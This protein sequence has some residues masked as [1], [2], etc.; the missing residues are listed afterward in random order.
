MARKALLEEVWG[1]RED[2]DTRTVDNFIA[3]LRRYLEAEPSHPR[4]LLTVRGVG[5]R[6]LAEPDEQ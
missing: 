5:Y 4:H 2:T 1:V 6:F 3:R